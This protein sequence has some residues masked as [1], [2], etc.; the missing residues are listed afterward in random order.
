MNKQELIDYC[1]AI[2][3]NKSQIINCIDVRNYQKNRTTRR[4][5]E[6]NNPASGRRLDRMDKKR[7]PRFTRRNELDIRRRK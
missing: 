6:N 1:N 2:K 4:T 5:A 3:E 7:R